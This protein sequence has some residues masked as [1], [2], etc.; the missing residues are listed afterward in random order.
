[1]KLIYNQNV[2]IDTNVLDEFL[3]DLALGN[4]REERVAQFESVV[5]LADILNDSGMFV[6]L[7]STTSFQKSMWSLGFVRGIEF[8]KRQARKEAQDQVPGQ[9]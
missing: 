5:R 1:M 4:K 3:T 7:E 6:A 8:Q 9:N 2:T